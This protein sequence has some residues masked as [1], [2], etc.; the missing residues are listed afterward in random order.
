MRKQWQIEKTNR[1]YFKLCTRDRNEVNTIVI[2]QFKKPVYKRLKPEE[3]IVRVMG[4]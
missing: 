4:R 1:A 2:K 3:L